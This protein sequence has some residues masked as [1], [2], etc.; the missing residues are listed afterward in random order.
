MAKYASGPFSDNGDARKVLQAEF[1]SKGPYAYLACKQQA[2]DETVTLSNTSRKR[3]KR[4]DMTIIYVW[5]F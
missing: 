5:K 1:P 2:D 4:G 3:R